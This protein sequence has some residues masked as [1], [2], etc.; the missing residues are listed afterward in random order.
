MNS[1]AR[2]DMTQRFR[3]PFVD[4]TLPMR[5]LF[6]VSEQPG[7]GVFEPRWPPSAHPAITTPVA[8]AVDEAHL[9]NYLLPRDCAWVA[10]HR[11]PGSNARDL[12]TFFADDGA[13]AHIVAIESAWFERART[14]TLWVDEFAPAP[15]ACTDTTAGYFVAPVPVVPVGCRRIDRPL[16]ELTASSAVLR[17]L[18]SLLE[19][20]DAVVSSSLA[21]S[22][23][24]MRNAG[25]GPPGV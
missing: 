4:P 17:V 14:A 19:L 16:A 23:I 21:F 6:H 8:W 7:I 1:F 2:V 3:R 25:Q 11:R 10:F 20:A 5:R 24:R 13:A 18:P 12:S 9:P 15:F 22:C